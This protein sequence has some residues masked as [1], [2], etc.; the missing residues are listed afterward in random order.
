[1]CDIGLNV[2]SSARFENGSA[3]YYSYNKDTRN[4]TSTIVGDDN[5]G[6]VAYRYDEFGE[7]EKLGNESLENEVCYTGQVYDKE[8]ENYYYN[9]RYYSPD[10]G[11]FVTVDTYRGEFEEPLS[12]HLYAYCANNPINFTDPSG[13]KKVDITKK[14][15][16]A[17]KK[18]Y[19]AFRGNYWSNIYIC[20][21][22]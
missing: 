21:E 1:M 18:H 7:T 13:H 17:M 5:V 16:K 12:L 15:R 22:Q 14:L 20:M 9:A 2:I 6:S 19:E 3:K 11:R 8:T 4:S 10:E